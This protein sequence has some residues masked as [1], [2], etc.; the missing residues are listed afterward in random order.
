MR[1]W[2]ILLVLAVMVAGV[3]E[4]INAAWDAPGPPAEHAKETVVLIP[5]KM[6]THDIARILQ[7]KG[8]VRY[9][10][11]FEINVR[12][13]RLSAAL[14]PRVSTRVAAL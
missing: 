8:V 6:G 11:V 1:F 7:D 9:P 10:F 12:V 13:R 3:A 4:W 14:P 5:P 2:I